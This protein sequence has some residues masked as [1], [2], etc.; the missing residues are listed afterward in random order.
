MTDYV[1]RVN[2]RVLDET[3]ALHDVIDNPRLARINFG[4]EPSDA[5]IYQFLLKHFDIVAFAQPD[6]I[7]P[8]DAVQAVLTGRCPNFVFSHDKEIGGVAGA[9]KPLGIEHKRFISTS[10][11]SLYAG[12]Y[13]IQF[14]VSVEFRILN[15]RLATSYVYSIKMDPR[16]VRASW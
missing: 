14:A 16:L 6:N 12:E 9:D 13:T 3:H 7:V 15:I 10:F 5:E 2:R 11:C 8:G 1:V 4:K